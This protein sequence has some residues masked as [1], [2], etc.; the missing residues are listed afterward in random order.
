MMGFG[1]TAS[2][3]AALAILA[4]RKTLGRRRE[5]VR[6]GHPADIAMAAVFLASDESAWVTGV[7]IDIDGGESVA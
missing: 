4:V 1:L 5:L 2:V 3:R 6:E 7:S